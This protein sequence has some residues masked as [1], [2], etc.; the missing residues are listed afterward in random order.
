MLH[1]ALLCPRTGAY[2]LVEKHINER[3]DV[4]KPEVVLLLPVGPALLGGDSWRKDGKR[5]NIRHPD[6]TVK[7]IDFILC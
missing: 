2:V 3:I 6:V 1:Q 4:D 5:N 7:Q